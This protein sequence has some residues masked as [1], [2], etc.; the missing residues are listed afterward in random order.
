MVKAD[1]PLRLRPGAG[2]KLRFALCLGG[3]EKEA[4]EGARRILNASS[5]GGSMLA[6]ASA[7][8]GLSPEDVGRAMAL[9]PA[10][11]ENRLYT[12]RPQRELWPYG[13]SGDLP[14]ICCDG[15]AVES[16]WLIKAFCL[17]KSCGTEAELVLL[18]EEQ[19]EYMQPLKQR[20]ESILS[21]VGLEALI[22]CPG[23]VFT[24]PYEAKAVLSS[25][26]AVFIGEEKAL[27]APLPISFEPGER[28]RLTSGEM[29]LPLRSAATLRRSSS[30]ELVQEPMQT[31]STF[32]PF[33]LSTSTTRSGI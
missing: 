19:G 2:I 33:K 29:V 25:R 17:I 23:G 10:L 1:V 16:E 3:S 22:G 6:A 15:R 8:L 30:E 4:R 5:A 24:A 28:E 14:I 26:A 21:S 9:L 7:R 11:W 32:V 18:S 31:W 13:I 20:V 12:A 27:P